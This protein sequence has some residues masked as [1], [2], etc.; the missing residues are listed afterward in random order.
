MVKTKTKGS[1]MSKHPSLVVDGEKI[2]V[3]ENG[4]RVTE[5]MGYSDPS[6]TRI[7]YLEVVTP[8]GEILF[9]DEIGEGKYL[10]VIWVESRFKLANKDVSDQLE[11]S[12]IGREQLKQYMGAKVIADAT[13]PNLDNHGF[14]R[15]VMS[16]E[17]VVY[18]KITWK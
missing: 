2:A 15:A 8:Q 13:N 14:V 3:I 16:A 12:W 17:G 5:W 10:S 11:V 6:E 4:R 7:S 1:N 18:V 9:E